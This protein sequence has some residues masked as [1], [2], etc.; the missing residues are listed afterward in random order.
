M[1]V[2]WQ[3]HAEFS[4]RPQDARAHPSAQPGACT[5]HT[6]AAL[7]LGANG[8]S[9]SVLLLLAEKNTFCGPKSSFFA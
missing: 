2:A 3:K 8:C 4:S 6:N 5:P 9:C 1:P 7:N